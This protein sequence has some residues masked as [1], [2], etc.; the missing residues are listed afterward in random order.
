MSLFLKLLYPPLTLLFI[1]LLVFFPLFSNTLSLLSML[2]SLIGSNLKIFSLRPNLA[3][4]IIGVFMNPYLSYVC[5]LKTLPL[6]LNLSSMPFSTLAKLSILFGV[7]CSSI[8]CIVKVVLY[9]FFVLS[10][11]AMNT[12][13]LVFVSILPSMLLSL[14]LV[15]LCKVASLVPRFMLFLLMIF[16]PLSIPPLIL[17]LLSLQLPLV[18]PT[19]LSLSLYC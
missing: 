11:V 1:D 8:S 7:I 12:L 5:T 3:F 19:I 10:W 16:S 4:V 14:P 15:V 13:L 2:N 9:I 17:F 18:L 6:Q